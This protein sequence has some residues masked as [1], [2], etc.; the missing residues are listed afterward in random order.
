MPVSTGYVGALWASIAANIATFSAIYRFDSDAAHRRQQWVSPY[1]QQ[2]S[3]PYAVMYGHAFDG[4]AAF[5]QLDL[6]RAEQSF[7]A[8]RQVA[9]SSGAVHSQGARLAGAVLAEL[10]Y[11]RGE[12]GEAERLL[13]ESLKLGAEEGTADMIIPRFVVGARLAVLRGDRA[14]A[15]EHLD[16]AADIAERL[17]TPRLRASVENERVVLGL[18]NRVS[19]IRPSNSADG[20]G[21]RTG[22]ARSPPNWMKRGQFGYSSSTL[23]PGS[24]TTLRAAGRRNGLIASRVGAGIARCCGPN[25]FLP[26]ACLRPV[27]QR[28]PSNFSAL[29][30]PDAPTSAWCGF[31]STAESDSSRS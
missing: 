14:A 9:T 2:N 20:S 8:A 16:H 23:G 29:S 13:D 27:E 7:R 31:R 21:P 15:A 17:S 12:T 18:P 11:Q 5:E 4:I 10:L 22:L 30:L 6:E 19:P 26:N 25:A 28:K 3:G 1:H 24:R